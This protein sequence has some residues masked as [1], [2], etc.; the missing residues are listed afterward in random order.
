MK[1]T[2]DG[3]DAISIIRQMFWYN[4]KKYAHIDIMVSNFYDIQAEERRSRKIARK[5][6]EREQ[7]LLGVEERRLRM[8]KEAKKRKV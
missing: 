7:Q 2:D 1:K 6:D 8:R 4:P 3:A 5:E